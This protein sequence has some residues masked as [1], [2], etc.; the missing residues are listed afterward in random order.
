[1]RAYN[2]T[3]I[4]EADIRK[5]AVTTPFGLFESVGVPLGFSYAD[6]TFQRFTNKVTKVLNYT[7]VYLDNILFTSHSKK[8][9][10]TYLRAV[11]NPISENEATG[12]ASKCDLGKPSVTFLGHIVSSSAKAPLL[13]NA[14]DI[15]DYW[16]PRSYQKLRHFVGLI[17]VYWYF[18]LNCAEIIASFTD[19]FVGVCDFAKQAFTSTEDTNI[20]V[21]LLKHPDLLAAIFL[22][23]HASHTAGKAVLQ[24]YT[25]D[26]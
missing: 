2:K 8:Q 25:D 3:F 1:M 15:L 26:F 14:D 10:S 6:R 4:D 13:S 24:E 12:I 9:Q 7:H 17:D 23:T 19:L 21:A 5:T 16:G 20:K 11:F 18:T 22:I